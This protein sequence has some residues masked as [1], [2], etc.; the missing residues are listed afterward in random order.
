M[1]RFSRDETSS[2]YFSIDIIS[3][4]TNEFKDDHLISDSMERCLAKSGTTH[5]DDPTIRR[6]T[7]ILEKYSEEEEMQPE[8]D[9]PK[10]KLKVLHS[11]L[12]YVYLEQEL[13]LVIISSSLK[14]LIEELK[15]HKGTL[16]W[17]I[18][19]IKAISIVVCTH[20]ILM[21]DCYKPIVQPQRRLNLA[22]AE[23]GKK[24]IVKLLATGI[25]YPISDSP[26]E[27]RHFMVTDGIVL[28][29]KIIA[30][31]IEVYKAKIDLI[32]GLPPPTTIKCIRSF[33]GYAGF[34]RRA[35]ETL[36]EKLSTA[37]VDVSPDWNQP[38]EVMCDAS[39]MTVGAVLGQRKDKIFYPIYYASRTLMP[40]QLEDKA[41][42]SED[43][44]RRLERFKKYDP[45]MFSGLASDDALGFLEECH[46][47]LRT[48][49][50]VVHY[51][52][53]ASHAPALVSTV[54][55]RVRWFLEGLIPSIRSS[56]DRELEMDISYQQMVS[57]GR[58]IK[59]MHSREQQY[60][61]PHLLF[62]KDKVQHGDPRDVTIGDDGIHSP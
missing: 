14:R 13:F 49:E 62:L 51:T 56:M 37:L 11:H 29:H 3:N 21:E 41:A 34:Y 47:I 6:E 2:S 38:F 54:R 59:G 46:C 60:D 48:M 1:I 30:K 52:S 19:G 22:N 61:D 40:V 10:I 12:K 33:L 36:K 39:D 25:I 24:E 17:T 35:F 18:E 4:L 15:A 45:P 7:E 57:I 27:K 16:G 23:S 55:E 26:G 43:E 32:V 50:Y 58:R 9:Q 8:V 28:V 5:D 44:Q 42:A 53:L 31:G 20:R